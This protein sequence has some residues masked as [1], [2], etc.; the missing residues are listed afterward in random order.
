MSNLKRKAMAV[1]AAV[2]IL[3]GMFPATGQASDKCPEGEHVFSGTETTE[4]SCVDNGYTYAV[5]EN[6]EEKRVVSVT[7]AI[8]HSF[9]EWEDLE[10][11][12][13]VLRCENCDYEITTHRVFGDDRYETSLAVADILKED[14]GKDFDTIVVAD[15]TGFAD[16]LSGSYLAE[17]FEAPVLLTARNDRIM[18]QTADYIKDNLEDGGVVYILGGE[19]AVSGDFESY[20]SE[21]DCK[22]KRLSGENRYETNLLILDEIGVYCGDSLIVCTGKNFADALSASVLSNPIMIVPDRLTDSQKEFLDLLGTNTPI[23]IIGGEGAV[24]ASVEEELKQYGYVSRVYGANRYETSIEIAKKYFTDD[25]GMIMAYSE[26]PA[27]GLVAGT[28]ASITAGPLIITLNNDKWSSLISDYIMD[29]RIKA[30]ECYIVGGPSRISD[31]TSRK[32]L[33]NMGQYYKEYV[34]SGAFEYR[35]L[36]DGT[37][38]IVDYFGYQMVEKQYEVDIPAELDGYKVTSIGNDAFKYLPITK[39]TVP[40][41]VTV[42]GDSAFYGCWK[43]TE[44]D[45]PS[46]L[47][48]IDNDSFALCDKLQSITLP[49]G[50]TYI[51]ESAFEFSEILE[52][53]E[54][55]ESLE[56]IG[57]A[58]FYYCPIKDSVFIP[59]NV[60][61]LGREVFG[62]NVLLKE[63]S[64]DESNENYCSENNM[65]F[66]KDRSTLIFV[67][68]GIESENIVLPEGVTRLCGGAMAGCKNIKTVSLPDGLKVIGVDSLAVIENM[69]GITIPDTV[70]A[71]GYYGLSYNDNLKEINIPGSVRV[72]EPDTFRACHALTEVVLNEGTEIIYDEAFDACK[73][74]KKIYI[75]NSVTEIRRDAIPDNSE[76]VLYVYEGSYA[77]SFAKKYDYDYEYYEPA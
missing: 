45:L 28:L 1:L 66:S 24:S 12:S 39:V 14:R 16:A 62:G 2:S 63:I 60:A 47:R 15:G 31:E 42:I 36:D 17:V 56:Y 76:L 30:Y 13:S 37:A 40:E 57:E 77:E 64:V 54:L 23:D 70:V 67:P 41:G 51:G 49:E 32:V 6:C 21:K 38:E 52:G 8:E 26:D 61:Y 53:I 73:V 19:G 11:N 58:A 10:D 44:V 72:I 27:D 55:P 35:V 7:P 34:Y 20:L 33:E 29:A 48:T 18:A 9:A 25:D 68:R 4:P 59:K 74:L 75:P 50:I 65:V 69:E 46:T 5:C 71:I 43:L 22:I 3:A